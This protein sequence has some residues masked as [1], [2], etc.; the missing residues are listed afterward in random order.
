MTLLRFDG[1]A[2][3]YGAEPV[4]R[5]VG[6]CLR[7]GERI[8]ILGKS[9]AGKSTLLKA[10]YER[11]SLAGRR[12]A[13]VPQDLALVPQLSVVKNT[14]MGRLDDHGPFH[15][16][17]DL[18][19]TR[20]SSR[21]PILDILRELD[22]SA[23]ADRAIEGL[24]GGQKQRAAIARAF[25]RGGEAL[26]GDEP[27]SALDETQGKALLGQAVSRF[28]TAIFALHDVAL[29]LSFATRI[30]GLSDGR[31]ALDAPAGAV[32]GKDIDALYGS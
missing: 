20:S 27:F 18:V 26:I 21:V 19:W 8:A 12:I 4:L 13:L 28:P 24:S 1:E 6:V 23:E 10:V 11:L 32:S 30:L 14:L 5:D 22:L 16:L 15:N 9:G 3:G 31:I 29:A 17:M 25:F 7:A 2:L